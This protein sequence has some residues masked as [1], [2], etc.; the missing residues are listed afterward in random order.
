MKMIVMGRVVVRSNCDAEIAAGP[1]VY[2]MQEFGSGVVCGV[3]TA[4]VCL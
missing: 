4:E 3:L 2:V 1:F